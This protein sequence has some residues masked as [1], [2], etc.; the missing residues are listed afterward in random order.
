MD[1]DRSAV[2]LMLSGGSLLG[3]LKLKLVQ[4]VTET[5]GPS[6]RVSIL[7]LERSSTE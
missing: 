7:H 3:W 6:G 1:R 2:W 5:V 4:E